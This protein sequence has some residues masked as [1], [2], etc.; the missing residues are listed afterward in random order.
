MLKCQPHLNSNRLNY[1]I[2]DF[3]KNKRLFPD[4]EK[5]ALLTDK[6]IEER[7]ISLAI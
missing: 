3:D 2:Q 6:E 5:Y 1:L 4:F 7:N